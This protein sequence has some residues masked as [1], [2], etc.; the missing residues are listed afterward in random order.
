MAIDN[1]CDE[2]LNRFLKAN[3]IEL[4]ETQITSIGKEIKQRADDLNKEGKSLLDFFDRDANITHGDLIATQVFNKHFDEIVSNIDAEALTKSTLKQRLR[5]MDKNTRYLIA[6]DLGVNHIDLDREVSNILDPVK[7]EEWVE[8]KLPRDRK[9]NI[10]TQKAEYDARAFKGTIMNS[11]DTFGHITL[12]GSIDGETKVFQVGV[13]EKLREILK[14]ENLDPY[15]VMRGTQKVKKKNAETGEEETVRL[16]EL[17]L[18]EIFDIQASTRGKNNYLEVSKKNPTGNKVAN[19]MARAVY[20]GVILPYYYKMNLMGRKTDPAEI[21][22]KIYF[23]KFKM[24]KYE[25]EV[26][27]D[28]Q[29]KKLKGDDAV[30]RLLA[31]N[32]SPVHG[33]DTARLEIGR[34]IVKKINLTGDYRQAD[35]VI[36]EIKNSRLADDPTLN[37]KEIPGVLEWKSGPAFNKVA[38][39][40]GDQSSMGEIIHRMVNEAGRQAGNVKFLGPNYEKAHKLLTRVVRSGT[41]VDQPTVVL[42][43]G[44][45]TINFS[46]GGTLDKKIAL[47]ASEYM[48]HMA[49][50]WLAENMNTNFA[51][52]MLGF[53]RNTQIVKLGSAFIS[54][55]GDLASFYTVARGRLGAGRLETLKGMFQYQFSGNKA[56]QKQAASMMIDFNEMMIGDLQDRFRMMDHSGYTAQT[57]MGDLALKGSAFLAHST[58]K[59]TG[60][61]A[62]NRGL[63]IGAVSMINRSIGDMIKSRKKWADLTDMQ[64]YNFEKFGF[65]EI[66]YGHLVKSQAIDLPGP[67]GNGGGRFNIFKFKQY[68]DD[69][70]AQNLM[71]ESY[72]NKIINVVN[73]ISES[74]VLKP[75]AIDRAAVGFFAKPGTVAEQF[76]RAVTQFQTFMVSHSRK[77]LMFEWQRAKQQIK[78]GEIFDVAASVARIY[79]P[80]MI[81]GYGVV[82]A[83]QLVAGKQPYTLEE[84]ALR[85]FYYTNTLPFFGSL[86]YQNGGIE[87]LRYT[88]TDEDESF[89]RSGP[90]LERFFTDLLGPGLSDF[91]SYTQAA[92]GALKAGVLTLGGDSYDAKNVFRQSVSKFTRTLSGLNVLEQ[93]WITKGLTQAISYDAWLEWYDPVGYNRYKRKQQ[94]RAMNERVNGEL[95]SVFGKWFRD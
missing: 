8:S 20:E 43:G 84:A 90:T 31:D 52:T 18:E 62:W 41:S 73:D 21:V 17:V 75:G 29:T 64:R 67:N 76:A 72:V 60:F 94:N 42:P 7:Y 74:M 78:K 11:L 38:K 12:E 19:A 1:L 79:A 57:R 15:Q 68:V 59:L 44:I 55:V 63:T 49:N 80:M 25:L 51:S 48:E 92:Y 24:K 26:V 23:K 14:D 66:A 30:A 82:Q 2:V 69:N 32:L 61:N 4:P 40:L 65:D 85:S 9:G 10:K 28:G 81:L 53:V 47:S 33:N 22:P 83:K 37:A 56:E 6:R 16:S 50:P 46:V 3:G 87:L 58:L 86:Y 54:N 88:M 71:D 89:K 45:N 13:P 36:Q 93:W 27:E 77:I 5:D 39:A 34:R 35:T 91:I 95:Y 70:V